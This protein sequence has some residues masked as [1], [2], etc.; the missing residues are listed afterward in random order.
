M[1]S[2]VIFVSN[3]TLE[4]YYGHYLTQCLIFYD[5]KTTKIYRR[6]YLIGQKL[7]QTKLD[8]HFLFIFRFVSCSLTLALGFTDRVQPR[9]FLQ[10][11]CA[12]V[13]VELVKVSSKYPGVRAGKALSANASKLFPVLRES[14]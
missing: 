9:D 4:H 7:F 13:H 6:E 11:E 10:L 12:V 3:S 1:F 8:F 14:S 5:N 2:W